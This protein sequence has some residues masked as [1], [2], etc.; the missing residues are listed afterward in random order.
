M[1]VHSANSVLPTKA[2]AKDAFT[3]IELLVVVAIIAI[4]ASLLLP[5]LTNAKIRALRASCTNNLRQLGIALAMYA[6]NSDD[7]LPHAA[8]N[9]EKEPGSGPYEGY[10]LFYGPAGKPPDLTRP[11]N[12]DNLGFLYTSKLITG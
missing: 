5:A 7:K 9:P 10:F 6:E 3:L 2:P 8:F 4:L 1:K 11:D 12:I